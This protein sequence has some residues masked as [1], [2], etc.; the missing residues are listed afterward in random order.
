MEREA[1]LERMSQ[2]L[3]D[4]GE[5]TATTSMRVPASLREAASLAVSELRA[6]P[7]TTA[8]TTAAM[9]ASLEAIVMQAA[10]NAHYDRY[11]DSRPDL[12][13]LAVAA[14]EMDGHALAARPDLLRQA[15]DE[16][17][18]RHPLATP[19]DVVLWAEATQMH[20]A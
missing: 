16:I 9:R 5:G 14:A 3:A 18:T 2:L 1:V 6:A 8:L 10:L 20:S 7:S 12:A 15:A 4:P 11:P 19:E 17:I 13:D